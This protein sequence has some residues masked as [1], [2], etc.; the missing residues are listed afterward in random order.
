MKRGR[1]TNE[2][3]T[4][5][6]TNINSITTFD[7]YIYMLCILFTNKWDTADDWSINMH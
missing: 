4:I 3:T 2:S 5:T 7:T 1:N 6:I